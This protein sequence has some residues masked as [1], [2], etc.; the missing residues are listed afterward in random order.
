MDPK[1]KL[2]AEWP[3]LDAP[4]IL[5]QLVAGGVDFVVIGGIAMIILGSA[6]LTRD[7]DICF[8]TDEGNLRALGKVL[9]GLGARLRGVDDEVPFVADERTLAGVQVLTLETS[10]GWL[11]VL[12]APD[13][14]RSYEELRRAA[15]S[16][17]VAG[18]LVR[19]ATPD[20]MIAMKRAAGRPRD[21]V[22]IEELEAIKRV[23]SRMATQ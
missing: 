2:P 8:S 11:D 5:R 18:V 19:V 15:E 3:D 21:L 16:H 23:R 4:E 1:D 10:A 6:R 20:D 13:G 12:K 9:I 14:V 7:V 22:D 17:E